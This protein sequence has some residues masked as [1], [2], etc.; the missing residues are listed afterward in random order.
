M[1]NND[2]NGS[3]FSALQ[4]LVASME[5]DF[6]KFYTGGNKA[7]GTRIRGFMQELKSFAQSVRTEVQDMKNKGEG[8]SKDAP[9]T[10]TAQ[11]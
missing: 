1:N 3:R 11:A 6:E 10:P 8:D 5:Q 2:T 4:Q 9:G 7:A